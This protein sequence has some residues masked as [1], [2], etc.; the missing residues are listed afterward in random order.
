M[1]DDIYCKKCKARGSNDS[2]D[3][4]IYKHYWTVRAN[5]DKSEDWTCDKCNGA[6]ELVKNSEKGIYPDWVNQSYGRMPH[7]ILFTNDGAMVAAY[8]VAKRRML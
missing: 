5:W 7:G 6:R 8:E 1:S 4:L 2:S 3:S